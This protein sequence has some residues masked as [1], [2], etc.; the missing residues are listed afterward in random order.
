MT[1]FFSKSLLMNIHTTHHIYKI[2]VRRKCVWKI[3]FLENSPV[4]PLPESY[5]IKMGSV[6]SLK[7][8]TELWDAKLTYHMVLL[9]FLNIQLKAE[10]M[11]YAMLC[12]CCARPIFGESIALH[13][14]LV[15]SGLAKSVCLSSAVVML[16]SRKRLSLTHS[17]QSIRRTCYSHAI[18]HCWRCSFGS[19]MMVLWS[20]SCEWGWASKQV[21]LVLRWGH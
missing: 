10:L 1:L 11:L 5:V 18:L 4:Q 17:R 8:C 16:S 3:F 12:P 20:V 6:L 19:N 15:A 7:S 2:A 13:L 9:S 21:L 14:A